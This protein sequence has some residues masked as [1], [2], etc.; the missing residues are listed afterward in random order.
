MKL[1]VELFLNYKWTTENH[2]S[3][4]KAMACDMRGVQDTY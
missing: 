2:L 1:A 4:D 3:S